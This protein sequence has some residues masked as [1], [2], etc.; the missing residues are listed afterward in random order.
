V[1]PRDFSTTG[2]GDDTDTSPYPDPKLIGISTEAYIR[3]M[4]VLIRLLVRT[5]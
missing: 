5:N 2:V 4:G 1:A 3:N